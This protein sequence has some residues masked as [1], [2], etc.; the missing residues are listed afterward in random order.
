MNKHCQLKKESIIG[1]DTKKVS[2]DRLY[3]NKFRPNDDDE[4]VEEEERVKSYLYGKER[5]PFNQNDELKLSY[6]SGDKHFKCLGFINKS[7]IKRQ[8]FMGP[9]Y[10][11]SPDID[12]KI[13]QLL[14]SIFINACFEKNVHILARLVSEKMLYQNLLFYNHDLNQIEIFLF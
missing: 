3:K 8:W 1:D 7:L 2:M 9:A 12:S 6:K 4:Q 11:V 13:S 5:I 14:L 10:I